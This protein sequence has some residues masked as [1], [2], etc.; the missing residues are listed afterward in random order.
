MYPINLDTAQVYLINAVNILDE[1]LRF[2]AT[3]LL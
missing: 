2:W 3:E 1:D